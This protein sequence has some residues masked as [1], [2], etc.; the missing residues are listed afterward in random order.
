MLVFRRIFLCVG[1]AALL[2]ATP[3]CTQSVASMAIPD[4]P[5]PQVPVS[6]SRDSDTPSEAKTLPYAPLYSRTIFTTQRARPLL[7]VDKLKYA[8]VEMT[9]PVNILHA[10][11]SAGFSQYEGGDPKYGDGPQAYGA[12]Y[13]AA[14][15]RESSYR[16]FSDGIFPILFDEDPRYYRMGASGT[17]RQRLWYSFTRSFVTRSDAGRPVP[18]FA[19]LI[20]HASGAALVLAYYPSTS[21]GRGVVLRTFADSM[22][23]QVSLDMV[24]EF[25]PKLRFLF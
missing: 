7:G 10:A 16:L 4:A 9:R 21:Q 11:V 5:V 20:G 18:N 15:L 19:T 12:R 1:I 6:S 13:G 23:V 8:A 17:V 25:V 2:G 14:V 22:A 24:R 3:G